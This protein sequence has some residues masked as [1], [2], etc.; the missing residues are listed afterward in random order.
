MCLKQPCGMGLKPK[1][2]KASC[3]K[4]NVVIEAYRNGDLR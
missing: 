4:I 2:E 3:E 1:N